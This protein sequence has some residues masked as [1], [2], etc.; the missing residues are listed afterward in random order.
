MKSF[1]RLVPALL[2]LG[3]ASHAAELWVDGAATPGGDGSAAKPLSTIRAAIAAARGGDVITVR[4]GVYR[5]ELLLE[6]SGTAQQ[7]TILRGAPGQRVVVS[8]FQPV[9]GWQKLRDGIFTTEVD[10]PVDDFFVGLQRQPLS[11]WPAEYWAWRAVT[12][13]DPA[14]GTFADKEGP[15]SDELLKAVEA[16]P[17]GARAYFYVSAGN[18]FSEVALKA[19][20]RAKGSFAVADPAK[21]K[22]LASRGG[23]FQ[24]V[25]H[26]SLILQPGQWACEPLEGNRTRLYFWP[27][28]EDDLKHTQFP[29]LG[30]QRLIQVGPWQGV[31]SHIRIEGLEI[32]GS[33]DKAIQAS[34]VEHFTVTNCLVHHNGGGLNIRRTRHVEIAGNLVVANQNGVGI[35][36]SEDVSVHD[37]EIAFNLVDGLVVAGN[38]SGRPGGEPTTTNVVVRRNY[39]HHHLYLSH[40]D[41][42]QTY[43]GVEQLQIEDNL[44]LWGGQAV[45]TEETER[46]SLRNNVVLGTAAYA[47]ILGHG[48]SHH[49]TIEGNT[50]GLGGWGAIS[51]TGKDYRLANNLFLGNGLGLSAETTSDF[52]LFALLD[53]GTPMAIV[54]KPKWRTFISP[55]EI[56]AATR[57]EEHGLRADARLRNAPARQAWIEWRND[58][59]TARL[60]LKQAGEKI[61]TAGFSAGD[62]VE[63]NGDGILRR[64]TVVEGNAVGIEPPL[65]GVPFREALIWNWKKSATCQLDV[66]PGNDSP[67]RASGRDGRNR[68]AALDIAAYQ[69]GDFNGDGTRDIPQLSP[70]FKAAW[71]DP[72]RI[73]LPWTGQ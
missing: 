50:I 28:R 6:K 21:L 65:S 70:D 64:I 38:I 11:R 29:R 43:R 47:I 52:N 4:A 26:E 57:Q 37:N 18:F 73:V 40:P 45:M 42:I 9:T 39:I 15:E 34:R 19:I 61:G 3:T 72:N 56:F 60:T 59:T 7:P 54:S 58:N 24:I 67:A 46:V 44:L 48:N 20:D 31:A 32:E 12:N 51:F 71:P 53:T 62:N 69:R 66:S 33:R 13:C 5:E 63:I 1:T 16:K 22:S 49:W 14:T 30:R 55:A 27:P 10:D 35:A 41:N 68:G 36:S 8:G 2:C 25:N 23:R 17:A